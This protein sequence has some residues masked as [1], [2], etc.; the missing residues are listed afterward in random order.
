M[1]Y[2]CDLIQDLLPLYCDQVCSRDSA[3]AVEEHIGGCDNCKK[4]Y[5]DMRRKVSV[6]SAG[7]E[8]QQLA[9]MRQIR[10]KI[11]KRNTVIGA[12]GIAVGIL[13]VVTVIRLLLLVGVV[14]FAVQ[15]GEK[16]SYTST[17]VSEYMMFAGFRGHSKLD[18]FP[19]Q[20]TGSM[21][22]QEYYYYY[23]DTFLDPTSQIYLECSYD[24]ETY[25]KEIRRL[26]GI[27]EEYDGR[28]Q[29]VAYD[30]ESFSCPAYV[31][32][33]AHDHCYEY[34]LL[35]GDNRI[36]YIFLQFIEE[37]E[38]AFPAEYLPE[39]YEEETDGYSI[40]VFMDENGG[41]YCVY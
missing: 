6:D 7:Y 35:L 14:V 37:E 19:E 8:K 16:D 11:R 24:E 5:E 2:S 30:T 31:A 9:S 25:E 40:Y 17:D 26:K 29:T 10:K 23:A 36:A 28:V 20:A 22:A 4:I 32:I 38:I 21:A 1:K 3:A 34:A 18:V 13:L 33:D 39:G 41:G 15:E 12:I 27:Q